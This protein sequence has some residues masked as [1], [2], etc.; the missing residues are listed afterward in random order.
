M[1]KKRFCSFCVK[2]SDIDGITRFWRENLGW[3]ENCDTTVG[4]V[5]V[6][7]VENRVVLTN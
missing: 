2:E 5:E 6:K 4:C 1:R 3:D 7:I